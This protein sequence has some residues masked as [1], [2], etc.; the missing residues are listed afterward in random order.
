MT[1]GDKL[2]ALREVRGWSQHELSR[3]AGVRQALISELESSKKQET[4]TSVLRRLART[5]H[6]SMDYL[7]GMYNGEPTHRCQVGLVGPLVF[8]LA[9][10]WVLVSHLIAY[11]CDQAQQ[12]TPVPAV[13]LA[14]HVLGTFT[15]RERCEATRTTLQPLWEQMVAE[16]DADTPASPDTGIVWR[17][18]FTCERGDATG[19]P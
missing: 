18:A 12:C 9:V 3:H 19:A 15:T 17:T 2:K 11:E 8:A 16:T 5:L 4:T 14:P 1:L 6:V 13:H 7:G 10:P